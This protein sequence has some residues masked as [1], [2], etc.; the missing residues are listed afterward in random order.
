[1]SLSASCIRSETPLDNDSYTH[2]SR[3]RLRSVRVAQ[4]GRLI[5][6][7]TTSILEVTTF[8]LILQAQKLIVASG[9][10]GRI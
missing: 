7:R 10:I 4:L 2:P 8:V 1:M 6:F 3:R 5:V 9:L